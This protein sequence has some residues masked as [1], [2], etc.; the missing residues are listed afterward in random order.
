[1]NRI[2]A[3]MR[4]EAGMKHESEKKRP[5]A[6]LAFLILIFCHKQIEAIC[7]S[8]L[9]CFLPFNYQPVVPPRPNPANPLILRI[10]IP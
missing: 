7:S 5:A 4:D 9:F 2:E 10:P 3:G 6:M 1:M 8:S